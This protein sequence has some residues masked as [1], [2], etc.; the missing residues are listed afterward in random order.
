MAYGTDAGVYTHGHNAK[1]FA[2][3]QKWGLTPWQAIQSAT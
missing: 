2:Y 3:M 1:Q